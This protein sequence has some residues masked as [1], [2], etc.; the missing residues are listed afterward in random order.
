MEI[1]RLGIYS[2]IFY[3]IIYLIIH[4]ELGYVL[5]YYENLNEKKPGSQETENILLITN[6]VFKWFPAFY[7]ILIIILL[8]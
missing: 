6:M 8:Y 2:L 4:I 1:E 5:K 3:F 7:V